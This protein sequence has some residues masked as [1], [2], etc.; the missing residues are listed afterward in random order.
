MKEEKDDDGGG[1]FDVF[2]EFFGLSAR[3]FFFFFL[4]DLLLCFYM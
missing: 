2:S 4:V 3:P 1:D